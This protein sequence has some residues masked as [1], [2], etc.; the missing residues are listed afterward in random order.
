MHNSSQRC[1]FLYRIR[2]NRSHRKN[3]IPNSRSC[4]PVFAYLRCRKAERSHDRS[5]FRFLLSLQTVYNISCGDGIPAVL[6]NEL[7]RNERDKFTVGGL[8]VLA[9]DIETEKFIDIFY[10][11][12][13]LANLNSVAYRAFNLACR[14]IKALCDAG[15]EFLGY[16]A[17]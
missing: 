15:I 13:R 5:A 11:S 9:V 12:S 2:Q 8:I 6:N 16:P 17:D 7:V 14:G 4:Q 3:I 1:C 10:L